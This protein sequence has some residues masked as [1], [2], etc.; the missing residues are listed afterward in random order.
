MVVGS[1]EGVIGL[2]TWGDWDDINDRFL[3]HP[4]SI[5]SIVKIDED[6]LCTGAEDGIIR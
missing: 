6:T 1:Q 5:D 2:F 3:G 4:S